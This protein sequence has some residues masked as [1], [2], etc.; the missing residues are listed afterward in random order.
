MEIVGESNLRLPPIPETFSYSSVLLTKQYEIL[1]V[2]SDH[3]VENT[4]YKFVNGEWKVQ[5]PPQNFLMV[6]N[7]GFT[8][9]NGYH[10]F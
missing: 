9:E 7:Q 8:M 5:K 1:V 10:L 3:R 4:C 6:D 2:M